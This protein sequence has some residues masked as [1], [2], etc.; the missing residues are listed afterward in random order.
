MKTVS[1]IT[2]Y[3]FIFRQMKLY[4]Q[5]VELK[6]VETEFDKYCDNNNHK[7]EQERTLLQQNKLDQNKYSFFDVLTRK[8]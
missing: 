5:S 2:I 6:K 1:V 7:L 8:K 4:E 3:T